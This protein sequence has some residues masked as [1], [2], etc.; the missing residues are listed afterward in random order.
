[1]WVRDAVRHPFREP[2]GQRSGPRILTQSVSGVVYREGFDGIR[3]LSRYGHDIVNWAL[4]EPAELSE[5]VTTAIRVDDP[6]L[7]QAL[8]I[9]HIAV[10]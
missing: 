9:L 7:R 3:Y 1:M 8:R 6:D 4:F 2:A 5:A 10:G